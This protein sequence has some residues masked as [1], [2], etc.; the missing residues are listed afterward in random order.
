[1]NTSYFR[2]KTRGELYEM[3]QKGEKCEV[4]SSQRALTPPLLQSLAILKK[5]ELKIRIKFSENIGWDIYEKE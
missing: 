5:E 1:M 4:V 3:L 2:P